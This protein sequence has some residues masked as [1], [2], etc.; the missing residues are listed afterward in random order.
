ME[1]ANMMTRSLHQAL[2][3]VCV[4]GAAPGVLLSLSAVAQQAPS[5]SASASGSQLQELVVTGSRI[6]RDNID[7]PSPVQ[8]ITREDIANSG[9]TSTSD[10]LRSLTANGQ[11]TLSQSF[12]GAFA[13]GAA[14]V[15]LR[16]M[17]VDATLVLIDGHR[18]ANYPISDDGQRSFVDVANLPL[19]VIDRIEVLKDG[20]SAV[21]GSD[22]IAGVVNV[23]LKKSITGLEVAADAGTS[24]QKDGTNEH[25]SATYGFGD[26]DTDGHNTYINLEWRHQQAL[27]LDSRPRYSNFDYYHTYGPTAPVAY[28][29][30][31]PGAAF[32]FRNNPQG[33]VG[34]YNPAD[35]AAVTNFQLLNPCPNPTTLGGCAWDEAKYVQIEPQTDNY[36]VLIRHSMNFGGGW[37]GAVTASMFES[38]AEQINNPTNAETNWPAVSG[39]VN[40]GDPTAQP[41]LIPIGNP[42][43]PY[44]NNPAWL[45]YSFADVGATTT[46]TDT[47]MFRLVA[48]L[49]G[50]VAGWTLDAS[51]GAMRG[52]TDLTYLNYVTASGLNTVL[53]NGS[54]LIG[55]GRANNFASVYQTLAPTTESVASSS[56]QY[57]ELGATRSL[58][59]L[60]G[61]PLA[62]AF[63]A[64]ARHSTQD[65]AGQPGTA[66][67][68]VIGYGT[69]FIHGTETNE[70]VYVEFDAPIVKTLELDLAGRFDNYALI[71]NSSTPKA[72]LKWQP[73][74]EVM[75]R[76]TYAKGFRAPGPGERG[77]SGVTFFSTAPSDPARC[78]FTG[79]PL[80]CGSGS[81]SAIAVG[82]QN[83]SPEKSTS[84][85]GGIVLQPI[86]QVSVSVDWWEIKRVNE[87]TADFSTGEVIRGP[88]QAA[89]PMLPG[90]IISFTGPYRNLGVDEPK[91]I[92]FE[93][94][95]KFDLGPGKVGMD[96]YWTH[97]ISQ[98]VCQTSDESTCVD[99][100]GTHGPTS[101][102][103]N[104][105][106]P[107]NKG[108]ATLHYSTD[109]AGG[110]VTVNYV[111]GYSDTDPT[112]G[113]SDCLDSWFVGCHIA[114]FTDID[115]FGHFNVTKRLELNAHVLNLF[116]KP[117]PFD[118][119]AGYGQSNYN[120]A[121]AQQ[122]AIGRFF[123]VGFKYKL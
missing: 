73:I 59:D 66:T 92:D 17:T 30:V 68:D 101:I 119:Q 98:E 14:G 42:N 81:A 44:P 23:I 65:V 6:I 95:G 11:G 27:S 57:L 7:T 120:F 37:S 41:F 90:P 71:G 36:N 88:V 38:K 112:F 104:T 64:G 21:Y 49:K 26:L 46:L 75:L 28:G 53:A 15:S 25:V 52:L 3:R 12:S 35:P 100:A 85:S 91:G 34:Q 102:S 93:V 117:A 113:T 99:V 69:T 50:E 60:P 106:T 31:Q 54:Y 111:S 103:S 122:G 84:Y 19:G 55:Q 5:A 16:G 78:P 62:M 105:G 58:F 114:S 47:K 108:M 116:N 97:L 94:H 56:L 2:R 24:S 67:A 82:N 8:M 48:D 45:A 87:I 86:P 4:I 9:F 118:P 32:P 51:I 109:I 33:M 80:D 107:A 20:A 70:N 61:G 72:G 123:E 89:Y 10:V 74:K 76:G 115:A 40:S 77:N 22:A 110:G 121:F 79:L 29:V 63:G 83:L 1:S 18:M 39:G 43:N 96:F 13:A